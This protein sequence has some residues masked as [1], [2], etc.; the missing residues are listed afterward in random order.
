MF[1]VHEMSLQ[2]WQCN[3]QRLH[4]RFSFCFLHFTNG[5]AL[6]FRHNDS[7]LVLLPTSVAGKNQDPSAA[8]RSRR[9]QILA[10]QS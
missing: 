2:R 7:A 5:A 9:R 10:R 3:L 1:A 8:F 4:C 6:G